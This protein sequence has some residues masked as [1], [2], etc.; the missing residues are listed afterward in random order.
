MS[1]VPRDFDQLVARADTVFRGTVTE[2]HSL[3]KGEGEARRIV[4]R[5]TLSVQ[6]TFKG[7]AVPTQSIEFLGG[8][9]GDRTLTIPGMPKFSVGETYVLFVAN[10]GRQ[11]CPLVGAYQGQF[12]VEKDQTTGEERI[13]THNRTPLGNTAALGKAAASDHPLASTPQRDRSDA[14]SAAAFRM[15]IIQKV[16]AQGAHPAAELLND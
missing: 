3:W 10:N 12:R 2:Q 13:F 1:V 9:V 5:V 7:A 6:E 4:T 14:I 11:I 8:T 16:Q 15:E